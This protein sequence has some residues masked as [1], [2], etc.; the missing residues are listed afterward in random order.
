MA[1]K[2]AGAY[3][4]EMTQT[5]QARSRFRIL[6]ENSSWIT[7]LV[8]IVAGISNYFF[9]SK[10]TL[11]AVAVRS[12]IEKDSLLDSIT[13]HVTV[14]MPDKADWFDRTFIYRARIVNKGLRPAYVKYSLHLNALPA[15][16]ESNDGLP[17]K[18]DLSILSCN[19]KWLVPGESVECLTRL[20]S[21]SGMSKVYSVAYDIELESTT[22][23]SHQ[24]AT[25]R[26]LSE[27][28]TPDELERHLTTVRS[29]KG[30]FDRP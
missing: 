17:K 12:A 13:P 24:S 26:E 6:Q 3:R 30:A 18:E 15:F 22:D 28:F 4:K 21:L 7:L 27:V 2:S 20:Q 29:Y 14:E 19:A 8:V 25:R 10:P 11:D 16:G 1:K 23:L 9:I 5:S